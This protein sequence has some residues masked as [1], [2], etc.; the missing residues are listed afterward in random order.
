MFTFQFCAPIH[1]TQY[2]SSKSLSDFKGKPV[3]KQFYIDPTTT[4]KILSTSG[5]VKCKTVMKKY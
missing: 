1:G 5:A 3:S 2:C 4:L